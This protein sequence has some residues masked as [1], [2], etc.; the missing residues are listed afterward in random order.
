MSFA[1]VFSSSV[2]YLLIL[3]SNYLFLA[4]SYVYLFEKLY[5]TYVNWIK[6]LLILFK[7]KLLL[8]LWS[9]TLI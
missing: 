7:Q 3:L 2:T 9:D 5:L 1:R 8:W 6:I 4:S